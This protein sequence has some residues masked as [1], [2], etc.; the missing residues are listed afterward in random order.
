MSVGKKNVAASVYSDAVTLSRTA[1]HAPP[2]LE[3]DI[4]C[5]VTRQHK[6]FSVIFA[7]NL[8]FLQPLPSVYLAAI[9]KGGI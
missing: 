9:R 1:P 7:F 2:L 6:T 8:M 5:S 4:Y 3:Q